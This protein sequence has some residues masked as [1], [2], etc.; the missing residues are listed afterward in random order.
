MEVRSP[1]TGRAGGL[2]D[3]CRRDRLA[4]LC[5]TGAWD[6]EQ[7]GLFEG[8]GLLQAGSSGGMG[9]GGK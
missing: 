8:V 1:K 6:F 2:T 7:W 9:P 5:A 3:Y 4:D